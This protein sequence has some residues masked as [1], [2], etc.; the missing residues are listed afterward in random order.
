MV[1]LSLPR[2]VGGILTFDAVSISNHVLTLQSAAD[3]SGPWSDV[4]HRVGT[5]ERMAFEFPVSASRQFFRVRTSP[6]RPLQLSPE[7]PILSSGPVSLPDAVAG[8]AYR[9]LLETGLSGVPPYHFEVSGSGPEGMAV[10]VVNDGSALG[11]VELTAD[12]SGLVP[13]QRRTIGIRVTDGAGSVI[14]RAYDV[15][16]IAAA[17]RIRTDVVITKAGETF[18]V[19]MVADGGTGALTWTMGTGNAPAS[20]RLSPQGVLSGTPSAADAEFQETGRFTNEVRVA[21]GLTDRVTGAPSPRLATGRVVQVVKLSY[22]EN[23]WA[24]RPG[25]PSLG[26]VCVFCHGQGF[27]PNLSPSALTVL[28]V[29]GSAEGCL[30]APYVIPGDPEGSLIV[31]KLRGEDCG[32]RMPDGGPYFD[33]IQRGRLERWVRELTPADKD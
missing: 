13:G 32:S 22:R 9:T 23:L 8:E 17:P 14:S 25:G 4:R 7:T 31:R 24:A 1:T 3:S 2:L 5:G 26:N 29:K 27:P 19:P 16:T 28:N 20:V 30:D 15:R 21:D 6:V 33:E 10:T 18:I 11:R 12:G